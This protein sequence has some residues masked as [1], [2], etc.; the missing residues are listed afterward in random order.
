MKYQLKPLTIH[1]HVDYVD[2]VRRFYLGS[3]QYYF[4]CDVETTGNKPLTHEIIAMAW[5]LTDRNL[6]LIEKDYQLF[7]PTHE[8][9]S[10]EAE[11]VHGISREKL[12]EFGVDKKEYLVNLLLT[13]NQCTFISHA[14]KTGE[15]YFDFNMLMYD[16][17]KLDIVRR[18]DSVFNGLNQISTIAYARQAKLGVLNHKLSTLAEFFNIDLDHHDAQ[19]DVNACFE[20]FK[21]LEAM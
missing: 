9:W 4:F 13:L 17:L 1:E 12:Q 7:M 8:K 10:K 14:Q 6:N 20:I 5:I 16:C 3:S 2:A 18:F 19:S 21:K 15:G 11:S